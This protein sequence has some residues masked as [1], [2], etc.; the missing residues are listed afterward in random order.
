MVRSSK[1]EKVLVLPLPK[2]K[3]GPS[4]PLRIDGGDGGVGG[5]RGAPGTALQKSRRS[6]APPSLLSRTELSFVH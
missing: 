1:E 4:G 6:E 3:R 2:C 5:G